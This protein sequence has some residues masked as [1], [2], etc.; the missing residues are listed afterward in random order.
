MLRYWFLPVWPFKATPRAG[1]KPEATQP[2]SY[3]DCVLSF[4]TWKRHGSII[5]CCPLSI[6]DADAL[7]LQ[8]QS[9]NRYMLCHTRSTTNGSSRCE[10]SW[11]LKFNEKEKYQVVTIVY[12]IKS[13]IWRRDCSASY[14]AK[15]VHG[16]NRLVA[17]WI[18]WFCPASTTRLSYKHNIIKSGPVMHITA[19]IVGKTKTKTKIRPPPKKKT[20]KNKKNR[21]TDKTDRTE[22]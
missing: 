21:Q 8:H 3:M 18:W 12:V 14:V 6:V 4:N 1:G 13:Y 17:V 22:Q 10:W 20:T 2:G 7:M 16:R 19:M 15:Q 11:E 5:W 9:T